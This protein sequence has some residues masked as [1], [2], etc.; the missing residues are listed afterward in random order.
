MAEEPDPYDLHRIDR[1]D[2]LVAMLRRL[3]AVDLEVPRQRVG[4]ERRLERADRRPRTGPAWG[5]APHPRD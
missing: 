2:T 5:E 1:E 3:G 4:F